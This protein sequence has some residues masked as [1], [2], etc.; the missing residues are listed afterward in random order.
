[1]LNDASPPRRLRRTFPQRAQPF[2]Y[3]PGSGVSA[4]IMRQPR[5]TEL[6]ASGGHPVRFDTAVKAFAAS[7]IAFAPLNVLAQDLES[8]VSVRDRPRDEYD[9]LGKRLGGFTLFANVDFAAQSTD[10]VFGEE[11]NEDSDVILSASPNARLQSNWSRHALIAEAGA[12]IES[13]QDFSNE[14]VNT[15]YGSLLGRLDIG[16]RSNLT[17]AVSAEHL[18]EPRIDPD[19]PIGGDPVEFDRTEVSVAGSHQF[20]R[21][22]VSGGVAQRN[23]DYDGLQSF[24][25]HDQTEFRGRV[26]VELSPRVGLVGQAIVDNREYDNTPG[27]DSDGQTLLA[28]LSVDFSDL[29]RGE[30]NVGQFERDYDSGA[31]LDGVALDAH[32]E[33]YITGLTTLTFDASRNTEEVAGNVALPYTETEYGAR[34]DHELQRNVILTAGAEFGNR[35][36]DLIEREDDYRRFEVGG[37]YLMNRRV[38]LQARYNY[39][40]VESEGLNRYRDFEVNSFTLGVSFRL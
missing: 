31:T 17:G 27:L 34:I 24:R 7:L 8:S 20:N 30:V 28:G 39:D 1:M 16:S 33:W 9:P 36:Y 14:D 35:E 25:D 4:Q 22:R 21:L 15:G 32:V 19:A 40:E 11:V 18:V 3:A 23:L 12:R 29:I 38:A 13:H 10:N 2:A 5:G 37:D 6:A 26:D